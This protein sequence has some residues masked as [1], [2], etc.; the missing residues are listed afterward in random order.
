VRWPIPTKRTFGRIVSDSPSR[1]S[2]DLSNENLTAHPPNRPLWGRLFNF[3][4][5]AQFA[6]RALVPHSVRAKFSGRHNLRAVIGNSSW[7]FFDKILRMGA[8][9]VVGVWIARYLG[10]EGFGLLNYAVAFSSLFGA[11][12]S[13]GMDAIVVR[14]LVNA[15]EQRDDVLG[16]AFALRLMSGIITFLLVI[17]AVSIM[18]R[19][20]LL[21]IWVVGLAAAGF[22]FQ[23]L[24]VIDLYFQSRVEA[25]YTI[26]ATNSAFLIV[27]LTKVLLVLRRAPIVAFAWA[28]LAEI[29]LASLLLPFIYRLRGLS[30]WKWRIKWRIVYRLMADSWPLVLSGIS[31]MI[32]MRV[33]QVL[34]GQMLNDKQ[35]G[36]YSAATR[37]SEIWYFIPV[38][39]AGSVFPLLVEAKRRDE[40]L[41]YARLQKLYNALTLLAISF[42]LVMTVFSGS[43]VRLLYGQKFA[44]SARV[45]TILIWSGVPVAIG[46]A[47]SN[48]MLLEN[49]T[50]TMF[51]FQIIGGVINFILNVLLIPRFGIVGSAY[52]T[53]ISYWFWIAVLCVLM[54]SQHRALAMIAKAFVPF[55][56]VGH[57]GKDAVS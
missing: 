54:K 22:I 55:L 17:V 40:H 9:L 26:Y 41:Y 53:L 35:V 34:I 30:A 37:I 24:N 28:A 3:R 49:R 33:D 39:I 13:F 31:I 25:R 10:P 7:I 44:S 1:K 18:R 29:V 32:A 56:M 51:S 52:A 23:S 12:A 46:C 36:I 2:T 50:K 11:L 57:D 14:E 42:A 21:A 45:L 20:E 6:I 16:S 8:G 15:P 5:A 4:I 43:I 48:W 27:A 47:W 19:G 38:G